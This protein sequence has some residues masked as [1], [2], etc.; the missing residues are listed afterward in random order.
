M[1]QM[2]QTTDAGLFGRRDG[3]EPHEDVRQTGGAEDE[4]DRQR[5]EVDRVLVLEAGLKDLRVVAGLGD[6]VLEGRR[7]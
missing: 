4:R 2:A 3:V 1:S 6:G 5:D 7:G